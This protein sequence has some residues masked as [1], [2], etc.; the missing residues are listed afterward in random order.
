MSYDAVRARKSRMLRKIKKRFAHVS[1][2]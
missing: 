2:R 1:Q